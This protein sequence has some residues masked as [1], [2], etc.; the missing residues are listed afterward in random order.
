MNANVDIVW[1]PPWL[2]LKVGSRFLWSHTPRLI[3]NLIWIAF[4]FEFALRGRK[5]NLALRI[6]LKS[7]LVRTLFNFP[8]FCVVESS[9]TI[10]F[11]LSTFLIPLLN[12]NTF[13]VRINHSRFLSKLQPSFLQLYFY[14]IFHTKKGKY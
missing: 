10:L 6:K 5:S 8:F 4:A 2:D 13:L 9:Y 3:F 7:C 11:L 12:P 1:V 14:F